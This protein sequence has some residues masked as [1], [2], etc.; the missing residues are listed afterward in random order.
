MGG[1]MAKK[2]RELRIKETE[3]EARKISQPEISSVSRLI[4]KST[5]EQD[6]VSRLYD[7]Q[8]QYEER[9]K[10]RVNKHVQDVIKQ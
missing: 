5:E 2:A 10:E 3:E 7:H 9:Q 6:V 4:A 8:K 1:E